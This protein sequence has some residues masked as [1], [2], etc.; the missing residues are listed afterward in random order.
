MNNDNRITLTE[1]LLLVYK[2]FIL[3]AYYKRMEEEKIPEE[4]RFDL[5]STDSSGLTGIG[6]EL[7]DELFT[8]VS[9]LFVDLMICLLIDLFT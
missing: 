5:D 2:P 7:L 6:Y 1:F 4:P 8:M 9:I 3:K